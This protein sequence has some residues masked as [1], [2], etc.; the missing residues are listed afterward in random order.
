MSELVE[1]ADGFGNSMRT[2]VAVNG[3][4]FRVGEICGSEFVPCGG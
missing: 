1:R 3:G 4:V 2:V